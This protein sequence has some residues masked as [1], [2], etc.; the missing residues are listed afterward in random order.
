[1][2]KRERKKLKIEF[3]MTR[4]KFGSLRWVGVWRESFD[5]GKHLW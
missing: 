1:M 2:I 3:V 4:T 5:F